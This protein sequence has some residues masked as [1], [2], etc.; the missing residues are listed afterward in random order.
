M[1]ISHYREE[2]PAPLSFMKRLDL[3]LESTPTEDVAQ[4]EAAIRE[5]ESINL[6]SKLMSI[7]FLLLVPRILIA[8]TVYF[9]TVLRFVMLGSVWL[10]IRHLVMMEKAALSTSAMRLLKRATMNPNVAKMIFALNLPGNVNAA[11]QTKE[12]R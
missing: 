1:C 2:I 12:S 7:L 5:H 6:N 9:V 8:M 11:A 10:V 3:Q 4:Q